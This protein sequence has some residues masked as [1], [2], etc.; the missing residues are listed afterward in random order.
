M[1]SD[2][3]TTTGE[4][5]GRDFDAQVTGIAALGE[6][7]R[8]ALYR[9]VTEQSGPVNRDEA[10]EGVSVARHVAKFH[11]DKLVEDGLLEVEFSRP[12]GRGGPAPAGPQSVTAARPAS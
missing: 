12:P 6:P 2:Q 10:A 11:L 9:Y 8:R 7:V 1:T 4:T 3:T 5:A